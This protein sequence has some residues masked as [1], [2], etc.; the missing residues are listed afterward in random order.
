MLG[1]SNVVD[2]LDATT[3]I[4]PG[5]HACSRLAHLDD[6][7]RLAAAF[8]RD[9]LSRSQKVVYVHDRAAAEGVLRLLRAHHAGVDAA[10]ANGQLELRRAQDVYLVDGTFE[11]ERTLATMLAEHAQALADGFAGLSVVADMA[12]ALGRAPGGPLAEYEHQVGDLLDGP[13]LTILCQYDHARFAVALLGDVADAHHVDVPPE[14]AAIV[15]EGRI[16]AAVI[17]P[18]SVLRLAGDLDF[19]CAQTLADVLDGHFH[20]PLRLD[21]ADLAFVDVAGMR[22]LRG[23]TGQDLLIVAAS[24][25]VRRLVPLLAW[26]TDP[27]IELAAG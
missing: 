14:L 25:S 13:S 24:E 9:G 7:E 10:M 17:Q 6:Q 2:F 20:G 16:A 21:L 1:C 26:D 3:A 12:W 27:G 23:R 8:V 18:G 22:A 15:R 4:R 5:E 11:E 19:E